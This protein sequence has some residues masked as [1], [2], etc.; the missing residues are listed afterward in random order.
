M[1]E[2]NMP[3]QINLKM[4]AFEQSELS[5]VEHRARRLAEQSHNRVWVNAYD[6]LADAVMVLQ[7]LEERNTIKGQ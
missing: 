6:R 4:R 2:D 3:L 1:S 7:S 5:I